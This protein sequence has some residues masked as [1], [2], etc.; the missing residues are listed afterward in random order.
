MENDAESKISHPEGVLLEP[1]ASMETL[2]TPVSEPPWQE[3][4]MENK[5]ESPKSPSTLNPSKSFAGALMNQKP[6]PLSEDEIARRLA[7]FPDSDDEDE[8]DSDGPPP[9][10]KNTLNG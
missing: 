8:M 3:I 2:E 7:E 6:Q 1:A 10:P 4:A 9:A 5:A